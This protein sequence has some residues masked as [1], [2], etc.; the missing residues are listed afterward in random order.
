LKKF[1]KWV[2]NKIVFK[3]YE[4]RRGVSMSNYQLPTLPY[5]FNALEPYKEENSLAIGILFLFFRY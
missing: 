2:Y 5:D 3:I 1:K 4:L